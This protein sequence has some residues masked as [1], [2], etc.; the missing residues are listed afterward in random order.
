MCQFALRLSFREVCSVTPYVT[1]DNSNACNPI[2]L[3]VLSTCEP[4]RMC[5]VPAVN[6]AEFLSQLVNSAGEVPKM[7]THKRRGC[8]CEYSLEHL[9]ML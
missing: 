9:D 8:L 4:L 5:Y 6:F 3:S 2:A 1:V 7:R